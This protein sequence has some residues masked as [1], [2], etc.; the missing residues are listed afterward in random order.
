MENN[1]HFFNKG[2]WE[3]E[4]FMDVFVEVISIQYINDDFTELTVRW[5]NKS[6]TNNPFMMSKNV[7]VIK[8]NKEDYVKWRRVN[9]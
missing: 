3:H 1:L 2:F 7:Q 4:K 5:W 6:Q 9:H 8:I